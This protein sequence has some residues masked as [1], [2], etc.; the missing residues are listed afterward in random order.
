MVFNANIHRD[1]SDET[2]QQMRVS[3]LLSILDSYNK[4]ISDFVYLLKSSNLGLRNYA[5]TDKRTECVR[6]CCLM[7]HP[8]SQVSKVP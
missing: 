8:I 5:F 6:F 7:H 1:I 2:N 4:D 3:K